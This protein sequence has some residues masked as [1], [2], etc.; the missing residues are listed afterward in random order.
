MPI[1]FKPKIIENFILKEFDKNEVLHEEESYRINSIFEEDDNHHLYIFKKN[2]NF[3]DFKTS[4]QGSFIWL[5][6]RLKKLGNIM[7]EKIESYIIQNYNCISKESLK[8]RINSKRD[9]DK[10]KAITEK[11]PVRIEKP[12]IFFPMKNSNNLVSTKFFS[13]LNSRGID[14]NKIKKFKF[15]YAITGKYANRVILP[16]FYEKN[17]VYFTARDIT[18]KS[19][20]KYLHPSSKEV[21]GNGTSCVLFNL[22]FLNEGDTAV[23]VEGPFNCFHDT[24]EGTVL[25]SVFGK[26][27]LFNQFKKLQRKNP[28]KYVIAYDYDKYFQKSTLKTYKFL[29]DKV[30]VPIE[31]I[32]WDKYR[33][34]PSFKKDFGDLYKTLK[35]LPIHTID[36]FEFEK[37]ELLNRSKK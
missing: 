27:L 35:K 10:P 2:G 32:D 22:D 36:I 13:Y 31:I 20:C 3:I 9:E 8:D 6:A 30:N 11:F 1:K 15:H 21:N 23:L 26:A 33:S 12:K 19:K 24:Q 37:R 18:D 29:K 4:E 17:F 14:N 5:V 16:I 7:P 34:Y 25:L 28:G